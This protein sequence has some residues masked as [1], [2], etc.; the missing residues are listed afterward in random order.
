MMLS[1]EPCEKGKDCKDSECAKSRVSP[2]AV[3]ANKQD[4]VRLLCKYQNCTNPSCPVRHENENENPIPQPAVTV[5]KD[6]KDTAKSAR[7]GRSRFPSH[8][9][10]WQITKMETV[11]SR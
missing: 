3:L 7:R 10:L 8:S 1:E 5:T 4:P 6:V 11:T 2:A 9:R